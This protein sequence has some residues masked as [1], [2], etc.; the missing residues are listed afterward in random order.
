MAKRKESQ[1]P[2]IQGAKKSRGFFGKTPAPRSDVPC[3]RPG[4]EAF[5]FQRAVNEEDPPYCSRACFQA[6]YSG[7][8]SLLQSWGRKSE[9]LKIVERLSV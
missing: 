8:F 4:C 2:K 5:C 9:A 3:S 1:Y 7:D 6:D